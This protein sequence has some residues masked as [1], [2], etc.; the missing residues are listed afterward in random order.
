MFFLTQPGKSMDSITLTALN[1][2]GLFLPT[3]AVIALGPRRDC[4]LTPSMKN[5]TTSET[6]QN[7]R[8]YFLKWNKLLCIN[9][10]KEH[11]H[12]FRRRKK[13]DEIDLGRGPEAEEK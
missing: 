12:L 5:M 1:I 7:L 4:P 3:S 8:F 11:K 2:V 13:R 6:E 9:K 10:S